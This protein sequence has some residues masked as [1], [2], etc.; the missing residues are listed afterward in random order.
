MNKKALG[1]EQVFIYIVVAL[2]FAVIMFFGYKSVSGFL[3]NAEEVQV[4]Q[5]KNDLESAVKKIYTEPGTVRVERYS[6]PAKF[7]QICFVNMDYAPSSAEMQE[8]CDLDIVACNVWEQAQAAKAKGADGFSSVD[9]N[10]FLT[11]PALQIKVYRLTI[12]NLDGRSRG[13]LC[14]P[15][16]RG[17]FNL[18]LQGKGDRTELREAS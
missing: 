16:A 10:V 1:V 9:E 17:G 15:I 11:P 8:L 4:V 18:N 7:Q 13:F 2:T 14:L 5:F 3:L 6:L 12:A